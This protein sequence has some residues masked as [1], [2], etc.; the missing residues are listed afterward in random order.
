[1]TKNKTG[2]LVLMLLSTSTLL[3]SSC[4]QTAQPTPPPVEKVVITLPSSLTLSNDGSSSEVQL[5]LSNDDQWSIAKADPGAAWCTITPTTGKGSAKF[6]VTA[7]SNNDRLTK[8]ID[9]IVTCGES[10]AIMTVQQKDT[11]NVKHQG[12]MIVS[13]EGETRTIEVQANTAWEVIQLDFRA[14]WVKFTPKHGVGKGEVE[15]TIAPNKL[16][17][18]RN[19]EI[20]FS[21]GNATRVIKIFQQNIPEATSKTDSLALV[22]LYNATDGKGWSQRWDISQ[23]VALWKGVTVAQVDGKTRVTALRLPSRGLD[24]T[25]PLEIGNLTCLEALDLSSNAIKGDLPEQV[26]NLTKLKELNLSTNKFEGAISQNITKLTNLTRLDLQKNRF[27]LFPVE[28]CQL[29]KLE[30]IHLAYNEL[31]SLPGEISQMS[32]LEFLYLDNNQ[33]TEFPK[34]L[35]NTP[36]LQYFHA[37]NNKIKGQLPQ[38]V[39]QMLSLVSLRLE[40]NELTGEIPANFSNLKNLQYLYLSDNKLSGSLPDMSAMTKLSTLS[41]M[42]NEL[43]GNVPE[44]GKNGLLIALKTIELSGN[45]L[46]GELTE[47]LRYLTMLEGLYLSSNLIEGS[48]P[49]ETLGELDGW[50]MSYL[51]KLKAFAI[52]DNYIRGTLPAGL[53]TRLTQYSPSFNKSQFR[54]NNNYLTGPVPREFKGNYGNTPTQFNFAENLYPQRDGVVLELEN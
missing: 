32:S 16:L 29:Q 25:I 15:F 50:A 47:N 7:A 20:S 5:T 26:A 51:P 52:D 21:A 12:D 33:L 13:N 3:L 11:L 30:Y 36:K 2:F 40:H 18:A 22:A 4:E 28:I 34:G 37:Y 19:T 23:P 54:V 39:G 1:M 41:I 35:E 27:N 6:V 10:T 42:R 31:S 14:S 8:S 24:G 17:T 53:A 44:F 46:K 9:I 49:V 43:S 38:A 48:L 45:K